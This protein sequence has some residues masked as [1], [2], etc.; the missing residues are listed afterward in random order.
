MGIHFIM[1]A[2]T[3]EIIPNCSLENHVGTKNGQ[4]INSA[5]LH[6]PTNHSRLFMASESFKPDRP[7]QSTQVEHIDQ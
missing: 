3:S 5:E 4:L 1:Q 2:D 6:K 7:F